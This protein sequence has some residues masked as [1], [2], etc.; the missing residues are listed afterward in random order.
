MPGTTATDD[1]IPILE[2]D[3]S[4]AGLVR[5]ADIE[6]LLL[7]ETAAGDYQVWRVQGWLR[8]T[9][10]PQYQP[11]EKIDWVYLTGAMPGRDSAHQAAKLLAQQ[12]ASPSIKLQWSLPDA[13]DTA[14]P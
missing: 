1:F 14:Q 9:A 3:G 10:Q 12:I 11:Q 8:R 6:R 7:Q 13:S 5:A 2:V 4:F